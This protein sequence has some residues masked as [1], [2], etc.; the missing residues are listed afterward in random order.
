MKLRTTPVVILGAAAALWAGLRIKPRA[1]PAFGEPTPPLRWVD[2]PDNLPAPVARFY[3][4]I[5]GGRVPEITSA[6]ID[7]RVTLRL[8][9][10]PLPGRFRFIHQAGQG[11]RHAI[12]VTMFG[13]PI[14]KVNEYYLD[15]KA[16]MELPFGTV[17]NEPKTD[18]AANL[19]LWAESI[20]LP[21][22]YVTDPRVRW[23]A[24][25][26]TTARLVVPFGAEEDALTVTFDP[27][28]GL[29]RRLEGLRYRGAKDDSKILWRNEMAAWKRW[30][31]VLIPS[32]G[33][34]TWMDEGMPWFVFSLDDV[35][36]NSDVTDAI[37]AVGI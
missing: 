27:A 14:M 2:M 37:R 28:T 29:L 32:A 18:L 33:N 17:A 6:V 1:V 16:R 3:E 31:G 25:D 12:E 9:G 13:A 8:G 23:E 4:V 15:G 26:A 34:V 22:L 20:W 19:G 24:V 30:H 35:T 11:Y 7:G 36:Y 21:S 10:I 5:A